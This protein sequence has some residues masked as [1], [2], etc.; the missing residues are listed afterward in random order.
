MTDARVAQLLKGLAAERAAA[1][2]FAAHEAKREQQKATSKAAEAQYER[3][4]KAYYSKRQAAEA[5]RMDVT[6]RATAA[7][8]KVDMQRMASM[9]EADVRRMQARMEDLQQRHDAAEKRGD[10]ATVAAVRDTVARE[11]ERMTGISAK[12]AGAASKRQVNVQA[13]LAKCGDDP[14][15]P[16]RPAEVEGSDDSL[17]SFVDKAGITASG[18]EGQQYSVMRERVAFFVQQKGKLPS[19]GSYAYSDAEVA[20]LEAHA[21]ELM[22][23]E[24]ELTESPS[25][26]LGKRGE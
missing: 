6:A 3:D 1:K 13:E 19:G 8:P 23:Y 14:A 21:A 25:D 4:M 11:M 10:Q 18:F 16:V 24:T 9:T 12:E 26:W 5:C 22:G 7:A 20:A 15:E 2:Q 17:D